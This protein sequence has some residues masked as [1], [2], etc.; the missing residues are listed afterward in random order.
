MTHT[1][2]SKAYVCIL[3]D[4]VHTGEPSELARNGPVCGKCASECKSLNARLK[5]KRKKKRGKR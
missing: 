3:C 2:L 1:V 4:D 5:K